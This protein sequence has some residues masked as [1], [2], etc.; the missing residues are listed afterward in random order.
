MNPE[1]AKAILEWLKTDRGDKERTAR[2]ISRTVHCSRDEARQ[3][4]EEAIAQ[5]ALSPASMLSSTG[6][7]RRTSCLISSRG[8]SSEQN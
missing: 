8:T 7:E 3:M 2:W 6:T 5:K 4:I 1:T